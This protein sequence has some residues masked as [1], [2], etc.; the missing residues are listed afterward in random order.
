MCQNHGKLQSM[1]FMKSTFFPLR[2][3]PTL[4]LLLAHLPTQL[5]SIQCFTWTC[6]LTCPGWEG[7]MESNTW[8]YLFFVRTVP[9]IQLTQ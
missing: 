3:A 4:A 9:I 8:S 1:Q 5:L 6:M 2:E 7:L